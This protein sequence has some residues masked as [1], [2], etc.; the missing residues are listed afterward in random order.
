M[1]YEATIHM[2]E[3]GSPAC[4]DQS[5]GSEHMK[6][7]AM[8]NVPSV[9]EIFIR[10]ADEHE[11]VGMTTEVIEEDKIDNIARPRHDKVAAYNECDGNT[12][13]EDAEEYLDDRNRN[14]INLYGGV[15]SSSSMELLPSGSVSELSYDASL[16]ADEFGK[17][18]Q[19]RYRTTFT[20]YQLE[21]LERAFQKTHYPDVFTRYCKTLKNLRY[22]MFAVCSKLNIG[23]F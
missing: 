7:N 3:D 8:L 4:S 9:A 15:S 6:D 14:E 23:A 2:A 18:K 20:S 17:R 16:E 22:Q 5:R 1:Q 13:T 12:V 11:K 19:R 21:E 10:R